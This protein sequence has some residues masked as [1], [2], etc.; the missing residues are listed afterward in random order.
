M[1]SALQFFI[2]HRV[3]PL[4]EKYCPRDASCRIFPRPFHCEK[5]KLGVC[6]KIQLFSFGA[7][8]DRICHSDNIGILLQKSLD[9]YSLLSSCSVDR[10]FK[11]VSRAAFRWRCVY[12]FFFRHAIIIHLH[13][14]L[15]KPHYTK[16]ARAG[17]SIQEKRVY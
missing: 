12:R 3:L 17:I 2:V 6:K 16:R 15:Q 7:Y 5:P 9:F 14:Q 1:D 11:S 13:I 10:L 4:F 8:N